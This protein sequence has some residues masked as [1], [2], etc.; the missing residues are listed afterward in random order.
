LYFCVFYSWFSILGLSFEFAF[1]ELKPNEI[2]AAKITGI[3][4][5]DFIILVL[6]G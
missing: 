6:I 3:K 1:E 4:R 5:V 2:I